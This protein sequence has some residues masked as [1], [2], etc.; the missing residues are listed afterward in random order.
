MG[1]LKLTVLVY[2]T[3]EM[4]QDSGRIGEYVTRMA[5]EELAFKMQ[6]SFFSGD[7]AGKPSGIKDANCTIEITKEGSQTAD[8]I[9]Y[10]NVCKMW[11]RMWGPSRSRSV[12][13]ANGDI[14]PELFTM[15]LAVGTAGS[16]VFMPK[17]GASG[18]SPYDTLLGRP[19]QYIEQA[20]TVGDD[21]DLMLADLSQYLII[22][23]GGIQTAV[24]KDIRFDYDEVCFRFIVRCSGQSKWSEALT[25]FKG[26]DTV[27]PFLKIAD[28]T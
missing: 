5:S 16:S 17:G 3:G 13:I 9:V 26:S 21:G 25:P 18:A 6:K 1:L 4:M 2:V 15:S 20:E 8:S 23:K 27:S 24:S 7:G 19:I 11:A 10:E 28:R 14:I 22:E 12:W